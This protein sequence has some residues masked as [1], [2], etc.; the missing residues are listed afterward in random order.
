[1]GGVGGLGGLLHHVRS[2][3]LLEIKDPVCG[4]GVWD[5]IAHGRVLWV[6][7]GSEVRTRAVALGC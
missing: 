1:M 5:E 3:L 2:W 6:W 4:V 7:F